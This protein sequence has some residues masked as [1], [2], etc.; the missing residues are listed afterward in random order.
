MSGGEASCKL[1]VLSCKFDDESLLFCNVLDKKVN[2]SFGCV[3]R[4]AC[5]LFY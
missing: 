1:Y 5:L 4:F 2:S 3:L